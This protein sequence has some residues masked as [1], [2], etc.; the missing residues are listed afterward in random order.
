[1]HPARKALGDFLEKDKSEGKLV[2]YDENPQGKKATVAETFKSLFPM[3]PTEDPKEEE[4][5]KKALG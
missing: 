5:K 3:S 4:K 2:A 1:M